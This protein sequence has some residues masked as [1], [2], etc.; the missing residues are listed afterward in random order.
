MAFWAPPSSGPA[1]SSS[2]RLGTTCHD[3][4]N[5]SLSQPHGPGSP[6]PA[7]SASQY[8]STSAWSAQSIRN[9]IDS[10]NV[11]SSPPLMPVNGC[12][13]IVQSTVT[14]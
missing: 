6:P 4:P 12:P 13:S 10:L 7:V 5:R 9:E 8:R 11:K 3:T 14:T 1:R 2:S